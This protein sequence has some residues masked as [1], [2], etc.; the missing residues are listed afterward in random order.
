MLFLPLV[1]LG[2]AGTWRWW[3]AW[4]S[5]AVCLGYAIGIGLD[6]SRHDPALLAERLKASP[7]IW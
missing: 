7:E 6:L 3:E 5:T 4:A 2:P 1:F